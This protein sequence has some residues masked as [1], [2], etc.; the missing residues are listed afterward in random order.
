MRTQPSVETLMSSN[1][2]RNL[3]CK[4][5]NITISNPF[6]IKFTNFLPVCTILLSFDELR[7][8]SKQFLQ[9]VCPKCVVIK[10]NAWQISRLLVCRLYSHSNRI[11]SDNLWLRSRKCIISLISDRFAAFHATYGSFM[12]CLTA[13]TRNQQFLAPEN[14]FLFR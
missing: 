10:L 11:L 7:F 14:K 8:P 5:R 2:R 9:A 3:G 4:I 13:A 6:K 12:L 1:C